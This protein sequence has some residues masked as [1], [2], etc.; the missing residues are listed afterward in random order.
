MQPPNSKPY[1]AP[2]DIGQAYVR[3]V[4]VCLIIAWAVAHERP[5]SYEEFV[6]DPMLAT[7]PFYVLFCLAYLWSSYWFKKH[8]LEHTALAHVKRVFGLLVDLISCA[9]FI[10]LAGEYALAIYPVYVTIIIGYGLRYGVRYLGP[11]DLSRH[12]GSHMMAKASAI[13]L[14]KFRSSLSYLVAMARKCLIREKTFSTR[15]RYLYKHQSMVS[16]PSAR[17]FRL[18]MTDTAPRDSMCS[19]TSLLS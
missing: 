6:A 4:I 9:L 1:V 10:L 13:M 5:T 15:W 16:L 7:F 2:S 8:N 12:I 19:R 17:F 3:L 11:V 18:G 14:A